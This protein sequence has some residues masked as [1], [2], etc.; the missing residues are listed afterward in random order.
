MVEELSP[1]AL[2]ACDMAGRHA[3]MPGW[4]DLCRAIWQGK[5]ILRCLEDAALSRQV[6]LRGVSLDLGGSGSRYLERFQCDG[7]VLPIVVDIR[8]EPPPSV[9]ANFERGLP[10]V[11]ASVDVVLLHNVLEHIREV[12]DFVREIHRVLRPGGR[13]YWSIPFLMPVHEFDGHIRYGDHRRLTATALTDLLSDFRAIEILPLEVG[14]FVAAS[15]LALYAVPLRVARVPVV[16]AGC[17]LDAAYAR[18]RRRRDQATEMRYVLGYA[19][20]AE[21]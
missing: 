2:R 8:S 3:P 1:S 12:S 7:P 14:P 18:T 16:A 21:K 15:H 5:S 4:R 11:S 13:L 17:L 19:G 10:F 6:R 20:Y 9:I